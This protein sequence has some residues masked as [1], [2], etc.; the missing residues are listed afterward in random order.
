MASLMARWREEVRTIQL[1]H[2]QEH[3]DLQ[4][5]RDIYYFSPLIS[6]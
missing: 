5:V 6:V 4:E 2:H 1:E 3:Q